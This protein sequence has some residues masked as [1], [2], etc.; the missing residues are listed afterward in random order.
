MASIPIGPRAS[1]PP[2]SAIPPIFSPGSR[3]VGHKDIAL[4]IIETSK[5]EELTELNIL[6]SKRELH[7]REN[8]KMN[9]ITWSLH[10]YLSMNF[11][12][13]SKGS[14]K[15]GHSHTR[16]APLPIYRGDGCGEFFIRGT[17]NSAN[18]TMMSATL[19]IDDQFLAEVQTAI[20]DW[21]NWNVDS[22]DFNALVEMLL[23]RFNQDQDNAEHEAG[24]PKIKRAEEKEEEEKE[25]GVSKSRTLKDIALFIIEKCKDE[26]LTKLDIVSEKNNKRKTHYREQ[27]NEFKTLVTSLDKDIS[28]IIFNGVVYRKK[29]N[30]D[31][32]YIALLSRFSPMVNIKLELTDLLKKT[33][34]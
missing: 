4:F 28:M 11:L 8:R 31:E 19:S 9:L 18:K 25:K 24:S 15:Q 20:E 30:L 22:Q 33:Q 13:K 14:W 34:K 1:L 16:C 10:W 29:D 5:D 27:K 23:E 12:R 17:V 21:M 7:Y 3:P 32:A 26:E 6:S 2:A